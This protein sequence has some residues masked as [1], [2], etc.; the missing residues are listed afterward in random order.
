[1]VCNS[2]ALAQPAAPDLQ[3]TT[4]KCARTHSTSA[5]THARTTAAHTRMGTHAR[6]RNNRTSHLPTRPP[7]R[8]PHTRTHAQVYNYYFY[9][10]WN[11]C[12][13][14]WMV[15]DFGGNVASLMYYFCNLGV[16]VCV[17]ALGVHVC[18]WRCI[19][20][21]ACP[22]IGEYITRVPPFSQ[23]TRAEN[24]AWPACAEHVENARCHSRRA[25]D[26]GYSTLVW[27]L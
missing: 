23:H 5:R 22:C 7:L 20:L 15:T 12:S 14:Q 8:H 25:Y 10:G 18:V 6:A 13:N 16:R 11:G 1:M 19:W 26:C 9:Y 3:H 2:H 17:R 27:N 24:E 21:Q 4:H